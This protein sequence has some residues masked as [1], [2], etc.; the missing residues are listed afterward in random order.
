MAKYT[1]KPIPEKVNEVYK[2]NTKQDFFADGVI[3]ADMPIRVVV[4]AADIEEA[5]KYRIG[6]TDTRMWELESTED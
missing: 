1:Y 3:P 6:V 5:K 4:E 2:E